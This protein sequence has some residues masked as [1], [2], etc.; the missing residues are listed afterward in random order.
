V[1][2]PINSAPPSGPGSNLGRQGSRHYPED[3]LVVLRESVSRHAPRATAHE[4]VRDSLRR[5]IISGRLGPGVT[6]TQSQIAEALGVSTTPVRE[7]LRDLATER[8]VDID[9]Y[10]ATSIHRPSVAELE[11]VYDLRRMLETYAIRKIVEQADES[12]LDRATAVQDQMDKEPDIAEWLLLNAEFHAVLTSTLDA[13]RLGAFLETLR[14][15]VAMYVGMALR[16]QPERLNESNAEHREVLAACRARDIERAIRVTE[17][18]MDPTKTAVES[19]LE[20]G[21]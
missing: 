2:V 12:V 5:A 9:N 3:A 20:L 13:P 14:S 19:V 18:H 8:L 10:R 6:F 21:L 11:E 17:L 15:S 1:A 7:A 4:F 16:E